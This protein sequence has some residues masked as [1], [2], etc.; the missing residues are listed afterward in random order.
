[1]G[2][3]YLYLGYWIQGCRKMAYKQAYRPLEVLV[4]GRWRPMDAKVDN[5]G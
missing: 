4:E 1:M 5:H 3:P 2:L